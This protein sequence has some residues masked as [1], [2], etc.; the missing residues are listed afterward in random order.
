MENVII[1]NQEKLALIKDTIHQQGRCKKYYF[2][3]V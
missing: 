2:F 3:K 1:T